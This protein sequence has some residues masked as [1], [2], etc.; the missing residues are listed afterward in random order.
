MRSLNERERSQRRTD[1]APWDMHVAQ[2]RMAMDSALA[3]PKRRRN[4]G[5]VKNT[6]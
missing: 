6:A 1:L 4:W 2:V 5:C 3:G